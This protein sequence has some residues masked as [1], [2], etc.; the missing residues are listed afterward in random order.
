[1]EDVTPCNSLAACTP[2]AISMG[3]SGNLSGGQRFLALDTGKLIV[4]NCLKE[5]PMPLAVMDRVNVLGCAIRSFLVFI[6][7]LGQAI[8]N[9]TT[10]VG[11]AGDGDDNKSV[12]NDLY[13]P[14]PPA[15]SKLAGV[16]LVGEGSTDIIPGVDLPAVV[17]VVSKPTGVDMGGPQSDPPQGNALFD[18]AV[19]DTALD[20]GLKT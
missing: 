2:G 15:T 12:V 6:D 19:F 18:D 14:A 4:R 17:D 16:S 8:G 9:Y 7:R 13:S 3:P 1:M 5:L 11:E 20:D 10:N